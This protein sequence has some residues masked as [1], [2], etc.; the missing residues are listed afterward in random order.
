MNRAWPTMPLCFLPDTGAHFT[1][2]HE[3]RCLCFHQAGERF[4]VAALSYARRRR[5]ARGSKRD[6][7]RNYSAEVQRILGPLDPWSTGAAAVLPYSMI[8]IFEYAEGGVHREIRTPYVGNEVAE[9]YFGYHPFDE[10]V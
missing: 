5:D 8:D 3:R 2:G 9:V 6:Q 10:I 4:R 7:E 1:F